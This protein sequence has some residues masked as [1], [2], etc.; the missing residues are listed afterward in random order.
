M[1]Y[2]VNERVRV[3]STG[4]IVTIESAD[5]SM[6]FPYRIKGGNGVGWSEDEF[7]P[8]TLKEQYF[9]T[10]YVVEFRDGDKYIVLRDGDKIALAEQDGQK[11][12]SGWCASELFDDDLL[13]S[14]LAKADIMKVYPQVCRWNGP[15]GNPIW[16]REEPKEMTIEEIEKLVGTKVKI[17]GN[18]EEWEIIKKPWKP[19]EGECIYYISNSGNICHVTFRG[20][21]VCDQ[22][23]LHS[24]NGFRT[25][26]EAEA[27]RPAIME[28]FGWK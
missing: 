13:H 14:S 21:S 27:N 3:K 20:C 26:E 18:Q 11:S 16:Q 9:Q 25:K 2:K 1:K 12:W 28:K 6:N 24:G 10:G 15:L 8:L 7:E 22:A 5:P 4:R 17:V 23:L 19:K